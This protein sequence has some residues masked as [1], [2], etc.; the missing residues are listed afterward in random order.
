[1]KKLLAALGISIS[2]G[3][4]ALY[5]LFPACMMLAFFPKFNYNKVGSIICRQDETVLFTLESGGEYRDAEGNVSYPHEIVIRCVAEDG[6]QRKGLEA[7][8][9][10]TVLVIYWLI[11]FVIVTVWLSIA[12]TKNRDSANS[13]RNGR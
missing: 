10:A 12:G 6:T 4:I 9:F 5:A 3:R 1:M 7:L 13:A 2:F 11:F 8:A